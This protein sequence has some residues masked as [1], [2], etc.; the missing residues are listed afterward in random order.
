MAKH[1]ETFVSDA[2]LENPRED[3]FRRWPFAQRIAQAIKARRDPS[4]LVIAIYGAWGDGKTTVLNFV[5]QALNANRGQLRPICLRYNPWQF[6]TEEQLLSGFFRTLAEAWD[7]ARAPGEQQL[8]DLLHSYL[9]TLLGTRSPDATRSKVAAARAA[10]DRVKAPPAAKGR[11]EPPTAGNLNALKRRIDALLLQGRQKIV[12][13]IDDV[14]RL[15]KT[16]IHVLFRLI[17]LTADFRNVVYLLAFDPELVAASLG[18]RYGRGDPEAGRSFLEKIIQVPLD[19]PYVD[20]ETLGRFAFECI[21]EALRVSGIA[22]TED[23][24]RQ[25][26][27]RFVQGLKCRVKTPRMCKRYGNALSF[28]LPILKGEVNVV[29][30]MLIEGVRV[31]YPRLY[32]VLRGNKDVVLAEG[33]QWRGRK[34]TG[35]QRLKELVQASLAGATAEETDAAQVLMRSLFPVV[36][37]LF[38]G[39]GY[40]SR[41][42]REQWAAE[43]RVASE[44]YFDRYFRYAVPESDVPDQA[45]VDLLASL[46]AAT[47][48]DVAGRLRELAQR[49]NQKAL[50]SKLRLAENSLSPDEAVRLAAAL[51]RTGSVFARPELL[52]SATTPFSQA[53]I[54]AARLLR[55]VADRGRRNQ[56]AVRLLAEADALGFALELNRWMKPQK[57]EADYDEAD[58]KEQ[59]DARGRALV[60]KIRQEAGRD[61]LLNAYRRDLPALL[62]TWR[63]YGDRQECADC[64]RRWMETEPRQAVCFLLAFV[65]AAWSEGKRVRGRFER[66]EYDRATAMIDAETVLQGLRRVYGAALDHPQGPRDGHADDE[67]WVAHQF[68]LVHA[69]VQHAAAEANQVAPPVAS[70]G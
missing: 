64:L 15:A 46:A 68:C 53:A 61:D 36:G 34:E 47:V 70:P 35:H 2:P 32:E 52:F 45:V 4:S 12:V 54:L 44:E 30:H 66:A 17:K 31:F 58:A 42:W 38:G 41:H 18:E 39:R 37:D 26:G 7:A 50:I 62:W 6:S 5:E 57:G 9:V 25:F 29:D 63:E 59:E 14:D 19:L 3:R 55:S 60:E 40:D 13:L 51:A 21:E 20:A 28:A 24:G 65:P 1:T 67:E 49:Y 48:E 23:Q 56:E 11:A 33:R 10:A 8:G 69:A 22:L 27:I 43:K 16:E